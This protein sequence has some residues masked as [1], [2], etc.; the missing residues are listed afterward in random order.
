[1]SLEVRLHLGAHKTATTHLQQILFRNRARLTEAR[2]HYIELYRL[3]E[4][5]TRPL[6]M[7]VGN[8]V[9]SLVS[10]M[11][12]LRSAIHDEL[13]K[14]A[15]EEQKQ[16]ETLI[17]SDENIMDDHPI[18]PKTGRLYDSRRNRLNQVKR[19][20]QECPITVVFSMRNYNGFYP[21]AYAQLIKQGWSI[22]YRDFLRKLDVENNRWPSVVSD[23]SDVFGRD[24]IHLFRY[25]DYPGNLDLVLESIVG[26]KLDLE[27]DAAEVVYPSLGLKGIKVL[28]AARNILSTT[29]R[30]RLG[31]YLATDFVFDS[32]PGKLSID[33]PVLRDLLDRMYRRDEIELAEYFRWN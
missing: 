28:L 4:I 27:F 8:T 16:F 10:S 9:P 25:E 24:R 26:R 29:E 13:R 11:Q 22:S 31:G 1:M 3:R 23:L 21:S 2:I 12:T 20:F 19:V 17:V 30:K 5:F 14:V 18:S 33:D 32:D 6:S 15:E 7:S